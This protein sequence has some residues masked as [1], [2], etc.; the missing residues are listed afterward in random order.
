MI[1]RG[2]PNN[3]SNLPQLLHE[4]WNVRDD[5]YVA[6]DM[7]LMGKRLVIPSSR[8]QL[9]LKAIHEGHFGMEKCKARGRSCV[10][11]PG[12]DGAIE[13]HVKKCSVCNTY[14]S[15]NQKEPLLQHSI[16][17]RPWQTVGADYFTIANQDYLLIVDYFSKYPEVIQVQGKTAEHTIN[18]FKTTFSR[19]G[20]PDTVIAD[21]MPFGSK[22]LAQ[23]SKEWNFNIIT[24]SPHFPQSNGLAER[25]VQTVKN[26]I[27]K[28]KDSGSDVSLALLELRNTPIAG[29][30]ESPAQL[31]M[32]RNL[33]SSLPM[34][35]AQLSTPYS[36]TCRQ[37][38]E[39]RQVKQKLQYDK[40]AKLLPP[41]QANDVVRYLNGSSWAQATVIKQHSTPRS[42]IIKTANGTLL[43]RNRKHLRKSAESEPKP[44][45]PLED[46]EE[47][48]LV[49]GQSPF[50]NSNDGR[51]NTTPVVTA[52]EQRSR[53]GRL[54]RP[55]K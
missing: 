7:I 49:N 38:L 35:P 42:Y 12:I 48:A 26:I 21:N 40:S 37:K 20:I 2:W 25:H 1:V 16:L 29:M 8:R 52:S 41:L 45:S 54:I 36:Q 32:G 50:V 34:M 22:R 11:W 33:R 30:A 19:H 46:D 53:Y 5:L 14:S 55:P 27:R 31:L 39:S 17:E 24:S 15:V 47:F 3:I 13:Q 28:A 4:F 44:V 9:V 23:F 10:Y 51:V 6:N 43:R 18:V